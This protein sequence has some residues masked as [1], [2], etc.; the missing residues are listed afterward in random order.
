[1]SIGFFDS[2]VGGLTVLHAAMQKMPGEHFIYYAD[3]DNVPYGTKTQDDI[4]RYV[5]KAV[6][7]IV[8]KNIKALVIAC[9]TATS[10]VVEQLR[11]VYDIPIVGMEPAIKP[12]VEKSTGKKILVCATDRTLRED[13]LRHLIKDLNAEDIVTLLSLQELVNYGEQ[14]DFH[15]DN[16]MS[17]L[18]DTFGSVDWSTYHAIV[19][20]C[21]HFI[22]YKNIIRSIIP[23]HV[24]V[25]DGNEGT[26]N[27][28]V[29]LLNNFENKSLAQMTTCDYYISGREVSPLYFDH[30][31]RFISEFNSLL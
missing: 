6:D 9:N 5:M 30:Y 10:V 26:V 25:I 8:S 16:L 20:G 19:L 27:R 28:L 31:M 12:A 4:K 18:R 1:M 7:F 3:I 15:S 23:D 22:F 2:G 17:Y 11:E 13:K 14:F 24:Q 29:S 21:T